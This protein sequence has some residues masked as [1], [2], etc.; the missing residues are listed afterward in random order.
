LNLKKNIK[1][2]TSDSIDILK[3][4][5]VIAAHAY[6]SDAL[7]AQAATKGAIEFIIP[8]EG[9]SKYVDN[10]V[11]LKGAKNPENAAKLINF[12]LRKENNLAFVKSMKAGPVIKG[13]R[14][15]LPEDL[16][17]NKALFPSKEVQTRLERIKDLGEQNK[18]Y[19]EIWTIIKTSR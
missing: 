8:K 3:N 11:I 9:A 5:E 15:Q 16:K 2:F 12:F 7:Q 17:N 4:K 1:L 13:V 19:E 18:L 14:E 10:M 6:S